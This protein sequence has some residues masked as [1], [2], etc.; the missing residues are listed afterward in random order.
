MTI[1][2]P[3]FRHPN[4]RAL[5]NWDLVDGLMERRY[6]RQIPLAGL[7]ALRQVLRIHL[8]TTPA[9]FPIHRTLLA[10][11]DQYHDFGDTTRSGRFFILQ[12]TTRRS[13][14]HFGSMRA[15]WAQWRDNL[16]VVR[17]GMSLRARLAGAAI[18]P[19]LF[20]SVPGQDGYNKTSDA[21]LNRHGGLRPG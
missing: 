19:C 13:C 8:V 16:G 20:P 15:K 12:R 10:S 3:S 11:D 1:G 4:H 9:S 6:R 2:K 5:H 17:R 18:Q 7:F 21:N 14:L